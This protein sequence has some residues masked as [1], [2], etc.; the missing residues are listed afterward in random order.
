MR[1]CARRCCWRA[2]RCRRAT[3]RAPRRCCRRCWRRT[4]NHDRARALLA[5]F[6]SGAAT[7]RSGADGARSRRRSPRRSDA[8]ADA[9]RR[10][11]DAAERWRGERRRAEA[12]G[13]ARRGQRLRQAHRASRSPERERPRQRGAQALRSARSRS[14][15]NGLEAI[16]GLGYCDLD[17]E[18]FSSAVD[19][20]KRALAMSPSYGDAMIG[21]A[22]AYKLRGDR[23]EALNWYRQYLVA[24]P[25]GPEGD[26]G[27]EQHSRSRA[28]RWCAPP[29]TPQG[30]RAAAPSRKSEEP[31]SRDDS[32]EDR[33]A[34]EGRRRQA[35]AA[36]ASADQRRAAAVSN[37][38]SGTDEWLQEA[39]T[40]GRRVL[41]QGRGDAPA[42][43]GDRARAQDEAR[44]SRRAQGAALH[45]LPQGRLSAR[46]RFS[47]RGSPSTNASTAT[48]P[49]STPASSRRSRARNPTS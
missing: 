27:E 17:G 15:P 2:S 48:A 4:R 37:Q 33:R 14:S 7:A 6:D 34:E 44:G 47:S 23:R 20:F 43:P 28:A 46:R 10:G 25:S 18:K 5:T 16:M 38:R 41:R 36:A 49:G 26:D 11:R 31:S 30:R 32:R 21:L 24:Q 40:R 9:E 22:E 39:V 35:G 12:G 45:A 42:Q 8:A 1:C 19:H 3:R 29:E 13:Q